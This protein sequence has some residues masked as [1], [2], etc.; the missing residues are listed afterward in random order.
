RAAMA[1]WRQ[2]DEHFGR[3]TTARRLIDQPHQDLYNAAVLVSPEANILGVY[4][5]Q[6]LVPVAERTPFGDFW[7]LLRRVLPAST[8]FTAGPLPE[9]VMFGGRRMGVSICYEDILPRLFR[10]SVVATQPELLVNLTSDA[11]FGDSPAAALHAALAKFRAV[12]HRL[13]LVRA[14]ND[15]VTAVIDPAGR[16]V[17]QLP[18]RAPRSGAVTV[19]WLPP[20]TLWGALGDLSGWF[21]A[22][23]ALGFALARRPRGNARRLEPWQD[24]GD[25]GA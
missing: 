14:T 2:P 9:P 8:E 19:Q 22:A 16:V 12:E 17:W 21:P 11:W 10:D 24:S 5:K 15:G 4:R 6:A 18:R 3:D 7:P 1:R 25:S 13:Y 20:A 23:L